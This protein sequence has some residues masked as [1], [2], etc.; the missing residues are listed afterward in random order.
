MKKIITLLGTVPVIASA[1]SLVYSTPENRTALLEEFT[2]I[3]CGYCPEGHAISAALEAAL[4][5]RYVAINVHAGGYAVPGT[6]EPDFRTDDGTAI[7]A[8]FAVSGYPAGAV[9]RHTFNGENDLGRG[10]WEGAVN[11]MLALPSPVNVGM[12]SSYDAGT[13]ELTVHVVAYY[14]AGSDAGNDFLSVAVKEDHLI[15]YQADYTNGEHQDYDHMAVLRDH[16]TD[17]WGEDIGSP[18]AGETVERTYTYV[19]PDTWTVANCKVVAFVGEYQSDVYQAR[20]V[21]ADGGTTLVIGGLAGDPLPFRPGQP[22]VNTVFSSTFTSAMGSTQ[23]FIV[24]LVD[25]YAPYGWA[26]TVLVNGVED[27]DGY[28]PGVENAASLNFQVQITPNSNVGISHYELRIASASAPNAPTVTQPIH[29]ISGVHDLI[30]SNPGAEEHW[31]IYWEGLWS[32]PAA[33]ITSRAD[34]L[35]F[36]NA[37]ALDDVNNLY[38]NIS[39]TFPSYSDEVANKLSSFMD[40]GGNLFI[41]GQDIGWDQSGQT[42]AYG[43]PVTQAFYNDYLLA[44]FVDD[45]STADDE[46]N[47]EAGDAVFGGVPNTTI[48]NI[49]GGT[50][51]Y[52]DRIEPIA[53][54]VPILR[55]ADPDKIGGLRAE[56][57]THKL[58]YFGIGPEQVG[59]EAVARAMVQLS[60]DWFYGVVG[61]EEFDAAMANLGRPYPSP[62]ADVVNIDVTGVKD[63]SVL[64]V[65]DASGRLVLSQGIGNNAGLVTLDVSGLTNG[66]YSV[67]ARGTSGLGQARTFEVLR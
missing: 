13:H 10:A 65:M 28:I 55:Y 8:F 67:R 57:P 32:E 4:K 54:A 6:G 43:T 12:E 45:G 64:E 40:N 44:N 52:P 46:A 51:M 47:F 16:I 37:N 9:N 7:D 3:H 56:T 14:T 24:S 35:E 41:A 27:T 50:N 42:G 18:V 20:E 66:L 22:S 26:K 59:D 58:V 23:D 39:W 63:A 17:T 15:G 34:Y 33:G 61:T 49:F 11:E 60:H 5:D 19:V 38:M 30:V 25:I 31:P 36:A 21:V 62:S 1:Q 53:P 48:E 29:V 2:G